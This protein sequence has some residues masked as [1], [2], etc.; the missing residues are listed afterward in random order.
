MQPPA[1]MKYDSCIRHTGFQVSASIVFIRVSYVPGNLAS[2]YHMIHDTSMRVLYVTLSSLYISTTGWM[3]GSHTCYLLPDTCYHL[4]LSLL[5]LNS[6][7]LPVPTSC[8]RLKITPRTISGSLPVP[9]LGILSSTCLP[10]T[11]TTKPKISQQ[12]VPLL[13][14]ILPM[15]G[16]ILGHS[17]QDAF[18]LRAT[19][20]LA[21]EPS[22][23]VEEESENI[24]RRREMKIENTTA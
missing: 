9:A 19:D 16:F 20:F 24:R 14:I 3:I 10:Y 21:K 2:R 17:R 23:N 1:G 11:D 7:H 13:F 5:L 15:P 4:P 6:Y 18:Q 22:G 8:A 12:K